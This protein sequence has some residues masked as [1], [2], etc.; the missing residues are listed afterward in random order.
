MKHVKRKL[1][2]THIGTDF[3]GYA[4]A[5]ALTEISKSRYAP[6]KLKRRKG[7]SK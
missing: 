7:K 3:P 6:K 2:V 5:R 1:T 4:N